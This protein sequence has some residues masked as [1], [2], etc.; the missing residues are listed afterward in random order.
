MARKATDYKK[1]VPDF[2]LGRNCSSLQTCHLTRSTESAPISQPDHRENAVS[3]CHG[4]MLLLRSGLIQSIPVLSQI[5]F[6]PPSFPLFIC[7]IHPSI[8]S[9]IT[10]ST[11]HMHIHMRIH[12]PIC[13]SPHLP[14]SL[15]LIPPFLSSYRPLSLR[16][17]HHHLY[18]WFL[19]WVGCV[20]WVGGWRW[21]CIHFLLCL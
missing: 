19:A 13:A 12:I 20:R 1:S 21:R 6:H 7:P 16:D 3:C 4:S 5:L 14:R 2:Y 11:M 17:Q 18:K 15:P 9:Y 8:H 10:E